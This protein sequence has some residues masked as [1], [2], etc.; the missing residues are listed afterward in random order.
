MKSASAET[1]DPEDSDRTCFTRWILLGLD[2]ASTRV[3]SGKQ[4]R[5]C[6]GMAKVLLGG[7]GPA[8]KLT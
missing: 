6:R 5:M 7:L 1:A 8:T 4:R 3:K 2:S